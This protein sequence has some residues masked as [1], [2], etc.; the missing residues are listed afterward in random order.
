MKPNKNTF[1][2]GA[3]PPV[4]TLRDLYQRAVFS[5]RILSASEAAIDIYNRRVSLRVAAREGELDAET[6][7]R[8][9]YGLE[10]AWD[11]FAA[12]ITDA[13]FSGECFEKDEEGR[14]L[15]MDGEPLA[16]LDMEKVKADM[17]AFLSLLRGGAGEADKILEKQAY[18]AGI[19]RYRL[20]TVEEAAADVRNRLVDAY[21]GLDPENGSVTERSYLADL[22]QAKAWLDG[23]M[24]RL[25]FLVNDSK[26]DE[27]G[28]YTE[29]EGKPVIPVDVEGLRSECEEYFRRMGR[30][31][32]TRDVLM[33]NE[34]R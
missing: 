19:F 1:S 3:E 31:Y 24:I 32:S 6:Y 17:R 28:R 14:I 10:Q 11:Y 26:K 30:L 13:Y 8:E 12:L 23:E 2:E 7:A 5:R 18:E 4:L 22:K 9:S 34:D 20:F 29:F 15:K 25:H 33:T 21:L 16:V 27:D